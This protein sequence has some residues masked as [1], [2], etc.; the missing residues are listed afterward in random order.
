VS[1]HDPDGTIA[2]L[3]LGVVTPTAAAALAGA[4]QGLVGSREA[5]TRASAAARDYYLRNHP[6]DLVM[7]RF[8]A[9]LVGGK[10]P[11]Y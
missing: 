9:E 4:L 7:E 5:W 3:G 10:E 8:E 11:G 1:T 2:D 6:V